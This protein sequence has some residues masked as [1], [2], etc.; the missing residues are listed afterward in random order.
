MTRVVWRWGTALVVALV[1]LGGVACSAPVAG[2]AR[3]VATTVAAP[4]DPLTVPPYGLSLKPEIAADLAALTT[5][6]TW[7]P[8]GFIGDDDEG[9]GPVVRRA[10]ILDINE[11]QVTHGSSPD[12]P[13]WEIDTTVGK[14]P[15]ASTGT[16]EQIGGR[17]VVFSTLQLSGVPDTCT[18]HVALG[19][20]GATLS[21]AVV[22]SLPGRATC[23]VARPLARA[24]IDELG[25]PPL[26]A[27]SGVAPGEAVALADPCRAAGRLQ[28]TRYPELEL[29][30]RFDSPFDCAMQIDRDRV[31]VSTKQGFDITDPRAAKL[32]ADA[33]LTSVPVTV[34]GRPGQQHTDSDQCSVTV[35]AGSTKYP[36][37]TTKP[38]IPPLTVQ[39]EARARTCD[40]AVEFL[41]ATLAV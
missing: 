29:N 5:W 18:A 9:L 37:P 3:P 15:P 8:C 24:A 4:P 28:R 34:A 13:A 6:R 27:T 39:L 20:N 1:A 30:P 32:L 41:E 36:F 22:A 19:G 40:V 16:A 7:D 26:R 10:I 35:T 25:S 23:D 21:I 38:D 2:R 14:P 33:G 31:T 12:Q 11:C 17:S